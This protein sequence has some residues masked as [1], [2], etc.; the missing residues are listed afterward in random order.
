MTHAVT[1]TNLG[2]VDNQSRGA[3][4]RA[5]REHLGMTASGLAKL[6]NVDRGKLSR[7]E[8]GVD[9]PSER[10][11]G[12]VERALDA[13]EAEVGVEPGEATKVTTP[14]LIRLTLHDVF[15]VGEII[16]EGPVD[17]PDELVASVAKLL[18]EIRSQEKR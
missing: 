14:E 12:G 17:K 16:A 1:A 11:I 15:G 2:R 4:V 7:F 13:F 3:A 9:Q 10:W 18:A 8:E 6:A 5:R